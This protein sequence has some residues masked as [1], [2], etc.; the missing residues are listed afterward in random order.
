MKLQ[1]AVFLIALFVA[2]QAVAQQATNAPS[3]SAAVTVEKLK[4]H[5]LAPGETTKL[6]ENLK[7]VKGLDPRAWT[8]V[9]GWHPGESAFP[10]AE[11]HEGGL[12]LFWMDIEPVSIAR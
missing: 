12:C 1:G 5:W 10:S 6:K 8:T 4:L 11:T 2:R 9:V 7:P 3:A